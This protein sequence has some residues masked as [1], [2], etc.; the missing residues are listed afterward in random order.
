MPRREVGAQTVDRAFGRPPAS[1]LSRFVLFSSPWGSLLG[2]AFRQSSPLWSQ[3]AGG[4]RCMRKLRCRERR[5]L[6]L[7]W[8]TRH[9]HRALC[10]GRVLCALGGE[11]AS[12]AP[13]LVSVKC[14][15][16]VSCAPLRPHGILGSS[17]AGHHCLGKRRWNDPVQ[18]H[19][20]I[21]TACEESLQSVASDRARCVELEAGSIAKVLHR[22]TP[23]EESGRGRWFMPFS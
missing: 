13:C 2:S 14:R 9:A 21:A 16:R 4:P 20:E 11:S 17:L 12:R 19:S 5:A 8:S 23:T 15:L 7:L 22:R 1:W 3:L 18:R 6:S 10:L